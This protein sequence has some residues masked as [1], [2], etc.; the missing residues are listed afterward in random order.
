MQVVEMNLLLDGIIAVVICA[1]VSETGLDSA[2][3]QPHGEA[4][5]VVV[6]AIG[7]LD[8]RGPPELT[9]PNHKRVIQQAPSLEVSDQAGDRLVH[10]TALFGHVLFQLL[11]VVPSVAIALH[12]AHTP[13]GKAAC[14]Q[15]LPSKVLRPRI[16]ESIEPARGLAFARKVLCLR[17]L[18]LHPKRQLETGNA[19]FQLAVRSDLL[20][21]PLPHPA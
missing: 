8:G 17:L 5:R 19:A 9:A 6:A 3:S 11:V 15:T 18:R 13:L 2:T 7:P 4:V 20:Q 1:A 21:L 14:Q 16:I 12:E 10:R